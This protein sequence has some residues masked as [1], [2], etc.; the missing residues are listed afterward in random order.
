MTTGKD[1]RKAFYFHGVELKCVGDQCLGDCP[2]CDKEGHFFVNSTSGQWDCKVCGEEGNYYTFLNRIYTHSKSRTAK[3]AFKRLK[4]ERTGLSASF[5]QKAGFAWNSLNSRWSLPITN[6]DG[7]LANVKVWDPDENRLLSSPTCAQHLYKPYPLRDSGPIYVTEGEWDAVAM[8]Q[9]LH[10]V[11]EAGKSSVMA[12]PGATIFKQDWKQYFKDRDVFLLY[13]NDEAGA[14][15]VQKALKILMSEGDRPSSVHYLHWRESHSDGFDLRD[16][17]AGSSF[18]Q[19]GND[20]CWEQLQSMLILCDEGDHIDTKDSERDTGVK[21]FED[22]L[23]VYRDN[24][25][26]DQHFADALAIVVASIFSARLPG[27]ALWVFLVGP[28][29]CGKT[30]I[31]QAF[32]TSNEHCEALSKLTSQALVSGWKNSD[33]S[34]ASFLPSLRGK[35]LTVKDYTAIKKM[36]SA[37]Q[38][39]LYGLLRDV[40]DGHARVTYGNMELREYND[41]RFSMVAGVTDI[42]NGDNRATLGERFLKIDMIGHQPRRDELVRAAIR[43]AVNKDSRSPRLQEA[44]LGF[45]DNLRVP[46]NLPVLSDEM[47]ER[48]VALSQ[49]IALLR[50]G[51]ERERGGGLAYRQC[52]ESG[53]RLGTQLVRLGIALS[54]VMQRDTIDDECYRLMQKVALDTAIGFNLELVDALSKHPGGSTVAE[55]SDQIQLSSTSVDSRMKDLQEL[56]AVIYFKEPNM[57][58]RRGRDRY[59]YQLS[60][61]LENLWS[62]ARISEFSPVVGPSSGRPEKKPVIRKLRKKKIVAPGAV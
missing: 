7:S 43:G 20:G 44:S 18:L 19:K 3:E 21:T 17:V 56:G 11:G 30:T 5:L 23:E 9:L 25:Y 55:L 47:L 15:G 42:I 46:E 4:K 27:D 49:L 58:G 60:D 50:A 13:D 41:L 22:L 61:N 45:L 52:P 54:I 16:L 39:E 48:L 36:S 33:G 28:P 2:F 32:G 51:V 35:A 37:V 12:V 31:L 62:Q 38:E 8:W 40:Y 14:K 26:V 53:G 29:S 10:A 57:S 34:D 59:V 24:L 6:G 1:Y